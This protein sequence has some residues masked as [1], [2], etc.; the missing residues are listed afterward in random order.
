MR[1]LPDK[2]V[3]NYPVLAYLAKIGEVKPSENR[4]WSQTLFEE[5]AKLLEASEKKIIAYFKVRHCG[6]TKCLKA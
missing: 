1:D 6:S 3:K 2:Y 4:V 5:V